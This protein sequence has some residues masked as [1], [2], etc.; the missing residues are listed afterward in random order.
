MHLEQ[1]HMGKM[2]Q[3]DTNIGHEQ[4]LPGRLLLTLSPGVPGVPGFP[5][6]P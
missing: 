4:T 3:E 5:G 2:R 6:S 1:F